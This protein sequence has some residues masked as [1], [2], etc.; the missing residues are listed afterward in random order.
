[1]WELLMSAYIISSFVAMVNLIKRYMAH[2]MFWFW[3]ISNIGKN[4]NWYGN[5]MPGMEM[6]KNHFAPLI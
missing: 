3:Q 1:M 2:I 5:N 6:K 4:N